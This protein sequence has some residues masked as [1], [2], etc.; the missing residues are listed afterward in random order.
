MKTEQISKEELI[1]RAI[2]RGFFKKKTVKV[3]FARSN[4]HFYYIKPPLFA[5]GH[6]TFKIKRKDVE[7]TS[8]SGTGGV[9]YPLNQK[10]TVALIKALEN[11]DGVAGLI[12]SG[13]LL[14]EDARQ[15]VLKALE[16]LTE[17]LT[18]KVSDENSDENSDETN[19]E[20]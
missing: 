9:E 12:E 16:K 2:E 15:G 11:A 7:G 3:I 14:K 19:K 8:D 5:D 17:K 13:Q 1:K 10:E 4:G 6:E 20:E 18:E